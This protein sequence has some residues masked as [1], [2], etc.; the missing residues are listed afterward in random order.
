[1]MLS[2]RTQADVLVV[3]A[4]PAGSTIAYELVQGGARV[5]MLEEHKRVGMPC[6]CAGLV[7][8]RT[9][10]VAGIPH[11]DIVLAS[12]KR[13]R[14]WGPLGSVAWLESDRVQTVA[15]DRA[16]LDR[17]LAQRAQ[18]IGAHLLLG[19]KAEAF[20]RQN[21]GVRITA[22]NGKGP[23]VLHAPIVIGADGV[24]SVVANWKNGGPQP[25]FL[26]ALKADVR[27]KQNGTED[28]E[29]FV[30][31]EIAPGWF[32]WV[33]PLPDG[34]ARLGLAGRGR[35]LKGRF[36]RFLGMVQDRFGALEI[37]DKRGWLI[38]G[39]PKTQLA[40]DNTLLVGDAAQQAKP[41]TGGGIYMS[42]RAG[43]LAAR[44]ALKALRVD[45]PTYRTL[46][47]YETAWAE[48]EGDELRYN[49]WLR[50]IYNG[51]NDAEI[52]RLVALCNRPWARRLIRRLGDVDFASRLFRPI[53][54]ALEV[55]SPALLRRLG[56]R[57]QSRAC[58]S[59]ED[60]F[61]SLELDGDALLAGDDHVPPG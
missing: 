12:F 8:P 23:E 61:A 29:I 17:H 16:R 10:D 2:K 24:H 9:L 26:P 34:Q 42:M 47:E 18:D 14:V 57:L 41:S 49:H 19:V 33:I 36:A 52:D 60:D 43:K 35:D 7:S 15:I 28:I 13:A 4:G 6:H 22:A 31:N 5:I 37:H 27:F 32:G 59:L 58:E 25:E 38:P 44:A 20:E 51:L 39:Q 40:F 3:G 56:D 54:H 1:M 46:S 50:T 21:G 55:V 53:H 45:D 11:E 48:Q 30:G